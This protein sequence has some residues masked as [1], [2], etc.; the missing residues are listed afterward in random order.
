MKGFR[1]NDVPS[2]G[3]ARS[4]NRTVGKQAVGYRDVLKKASELGI[5]F[6]TNQWGSLCFSAHQAERIRQELIKDFKEEKPAE[7]QHSEVEAE[8]A[9][10]GILSQFEDKALVEELRRRGWEVECKRLETL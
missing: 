8:K 2:C 1:S 3:I 9:V 10:S 7:D 6:H 4:V 5:T